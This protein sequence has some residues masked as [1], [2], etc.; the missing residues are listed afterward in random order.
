MPSSVWTDL[1]QPGVPW[2]EKL[3]RTLLVYVFLVVGLRLAGKRLLAQFTTFDLVVLLILSNTV[4]N[5]IIGNDNSLAGGL[6]GASVLLV[7]NATVVRLGYRHRKLEQVLEGMEERLIDGGVLQRDRL[8]SCAISEE[9]LN[10]AV[11]RQGFASLA[12][13]EFAAITPSGQLV[14][15]G[16]SSLAAERRQAELLEAVAR[17]GEEVRALRARLAPGS[18][19]A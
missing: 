5:A 7:L 17:V 12:E 18:E 11:Q 2:I 10:A 4:Q 6:L 13:V 16:R 14:C 9:E 15:I 19:G 3:L 1:L 8:R